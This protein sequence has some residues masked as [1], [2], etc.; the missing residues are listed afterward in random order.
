ML[1]QTATVDQFA[2]RSAANW[3][4]LGTPVG[5]LIARA[6]HCELRPG[7][8][9]LQLATGYRPAFPKA[10]AFTVGNVVIQRREGLLQ[11]PGLLDHEERHATQWAV[12]LGIVGFPLLY[13]LACAWSLIRTG[14]HYSRN[15]FERR[16]GL[17]AG[18][19]REHP[20]RNRR[21]T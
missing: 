9:R 17:A 11:R 15:I 2:A 20:P 5:L 4:T 6:S 16:A 18:G 1:R 13:G 21:R 14:D 19:Y 3:V 10:A 8:R 7:P 12:C